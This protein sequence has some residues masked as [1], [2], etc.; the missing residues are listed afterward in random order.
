M[1]SWVGS[2]VKSAIEKGSL[3]D[4]S[5]IG[6]L[7]RSRSIA[8]GRGTRRI[9]SG[10]TVSSTR[11][12]THLAIRG[13]LVLVTHEEQAF[14]ELVHDRRALDVKP[15]L[16]HLGQF[17]PPLLALDELGSFLCCAKRTIRRS[18]DSLREGWIE[19]KGKGD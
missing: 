5:G 12:E 3:A 17:R 9:V 19:R 10:Y 16:I 7:S 2:I 11:T 13:I 6:G 1:R 15:P 14:L 18:I 4:L 8:D